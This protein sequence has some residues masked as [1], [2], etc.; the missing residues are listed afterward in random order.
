MDLDLVR[1]LGMRMR[2]MC[3]GF[4]AVARDIANRTTHLALTGARGQGNNQ[5]S[6]L[7]LILSVW[8]RNCFHLIC[9]G[10][11]LI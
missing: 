1:F 8:P 7:Y 6:G 11:Y 10:R 4:A 5:M 9:L 3:R 2:D